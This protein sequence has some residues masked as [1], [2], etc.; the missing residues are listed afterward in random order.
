MEHIA[1]TQRYLI[2]GV[3]TTVFGT[4]CFLLIPNTWLAAFVDYDIAFLKEGFFF[5]I[6]G[7]IANTVT[8]SYAHLFSGR[9]LHQ[10]NFYSALIGFSIAILCSSLLIPTDHLNGA[11]I[12]A[13]AAFVSQSLV[14]IFL[15]FRLKKKELS[16]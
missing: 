13:S 1:L 5:L 8:V 12:A 2:L 11:C 6:P 15:F 16:I 7:I 9:G 14:Q 3:S 10:N 4:I